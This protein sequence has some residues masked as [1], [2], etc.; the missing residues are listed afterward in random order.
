MEGIFQLASADSSNADTL[1]LLTI[2]DN[3][4]GGASV[5]RLDL[6]EYLCDA[7]GL[8]KVGLNVQVGGIEGGA[9]STHEGDLVTFRGEEPSGKG[10][11]I[12]PCAQ[13][14][15]DLLRI[16][17]YCFCRCALAE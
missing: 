10:G 5:C 1:I 8:G 12:R 16:H 14:K 2:M 6:R 4:V 13:D 17:G 15:E 11:D 7:S 9:A 3:D